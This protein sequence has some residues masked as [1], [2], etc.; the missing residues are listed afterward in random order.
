MRIS[1]AL[2]KMIAFVTSGEA[3][4][5]SP[6]PKVSQR[7]TD[8][9]KFFVDEMG[10]TLYTFRDDGRYRPHCLGSCAAAWPPFD[11]TGLVACDEANH[12]WSII[13]RSDG[14]SQWVLDGRPMYRSAKDVAPGEITAAGSAWAPAGVPCPAAESRFGILGEEEAYAVVGNAIAKGVEPVGELRRWCGI[15]AYDLAARANVSVSDIKAHE[16]G[17]RDL[18]EKARIAIAHAL[19]APVYLFL[20]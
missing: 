20:E 4:A 6:C 16:S 11:A 5:L 19:G 12:N 8:S 18:T 7:D 9:G 3:I 17:R 15:S 10:M 1:L 13:G 14:R 2:A